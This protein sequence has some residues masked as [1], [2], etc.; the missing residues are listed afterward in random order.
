MKL[1]ELFSGT[2]SVGKVAK[3]LGYDVVSLDLK[4]AN[5]N[6]DILNWDYKQFNRNHFQIIWASPPCVAKTTGVRKKDYANSI[7]QKTIEII[8]Y[9]NP[10][11]WFI[12]NP[13]TGLLKHQDFMKD[14][15]YFD[16]DY[17]KYGFPYR[18]RTRIWTNLTS[19][20]P[21]PLCKKD[22]GN[23]I[24]N[25][26]KETAQR[27]P[28]GKKSDWGNDYIIHRQDELYRIPS[29]LI[30]EIFYLNRCRYA[31]LIRN[32]FL[33]VLNEGQGE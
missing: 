20:K 27:M 16:L 9:F 31:Q 11:V 28:S 30:N 14:F 7:V 23:I 8:R 25:K 18:K 1:L 24:N 26:H 15:D 33:I 29:E 2:G 13:Q 19:W 6:T 10:S 12:E 17:C 21:R 3:E 32:K 22:C 5:I 4:D